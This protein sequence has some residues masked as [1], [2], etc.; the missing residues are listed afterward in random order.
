MISRSKTQH[1]KLEF[2]RP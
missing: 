1:L 2:P